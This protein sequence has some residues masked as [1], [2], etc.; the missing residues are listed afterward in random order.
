MTE[1][2]K[3]KIQFP[4]IEIE[5]IHAKAAILSALKYFADNTNEVQWSEVNND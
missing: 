3:Y 1:E 5:G 4:V 2:I